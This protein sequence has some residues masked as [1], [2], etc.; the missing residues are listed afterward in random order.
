MDL[1]AVSHVGG[2]RAGAAGHGEE[3]IMSADRSDPIS[4][5]EDVRRD[6]DL[7]VPWSNASLREVDVL[8]RVARRERGQ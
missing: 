3:A 6:A 4:W 1:A 2:P 8:R 5:F 7:E